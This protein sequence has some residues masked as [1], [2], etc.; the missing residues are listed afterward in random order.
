MPAIPATNRFSV[1]ANRP[2]TPI[3]FTQ[4]FAPTTQTY[5]GFSIQV[6]G[7]SIGRITEWQPQQLDRDFTH[8]S[9][10]NAR[11]WG[12]PVDGVPGGAKNF[13]LSFARAEVW[14][15]ECEKAF[16]EVDVYT[17]LTNQNTPFA[18]DEVYTKGL[19]LY[20]QYRYLGC[21]WTSKNVDQFTADGD[22]VIR[23]SGEMSFVNKV[24]IK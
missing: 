19:Q 4:P 13:T 7:I 2:A 1:E 17:L 6:G 15:E 18:I 21:W 14:G 12:Q 23:I 16:G 11:T 5:H 20:R 24:R 8:I 9:E 3:D 10:L 22:G